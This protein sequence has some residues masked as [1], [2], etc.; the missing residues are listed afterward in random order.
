MFQHGYD[1]YMRYAFP[2]DELLPL[3][4]DGRDTWGG[5]TAEP[6]G[7]SAAARQH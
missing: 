7:W 5:Y 4:C 2:R 1:S 3:S 6:R